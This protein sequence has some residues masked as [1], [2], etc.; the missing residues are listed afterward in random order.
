[1]KLD[2]NAQDSLWHSLI[3]V[4]VTMASIAVALWIVAQGIHVFQVMRGGAS[5]SAR[6][7]EE[8]DD[9][10]EDLDG[11]RGGLVNVAIY[12]FVVQDSRFHG[13]TEGSQGSYY[14]GDTIDIEYNPKDPTQ[15][16]RKGDRRELLDYLLMVLCG[17]LFSYYSI[18]FSFPVLRRLF[19]PAAPSSHET[20]PR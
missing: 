8:Y 12:E 4:V 18:T 9:I 13:F 3:A 5:A 11:R 2:V 19:A 16:R 17:G 20:A 6:V 7:I 1:M 15:N 10:R 14:V